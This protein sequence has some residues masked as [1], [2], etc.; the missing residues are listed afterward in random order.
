M[1]V[2]WVCILASTGSV[3]V[4]KARGRDGNDGDYA[5]E[6]CI[7]MNDDHGI[8]DCDDFVRVIGDGGAVYATPSAV[9]CT[10]QQILVLRRQII[11]LN[12]VITLSELHLV[13]TC[14]I[15]LFICCEESARIGS[16]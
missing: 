8:D 10:E 6:K 1:R 4:G 7:Y 15:A 13:E 14:N 5:N 12:D 9:G 11:L 2:G 16:L 3:I